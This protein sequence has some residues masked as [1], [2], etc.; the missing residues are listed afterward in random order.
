MANLKRLWDTENKKIVWAIPTSEPYKKLQVWT[1]DDWSKLYVYDN[2]KWN[3]LNPQSVDVETYW[4]VWKSL[5]D[6]E[7][8]YYLTNEPTNLY[9]WD[10]GD[11][12]YYEFVNGWTILESWKIDEWETPEYT[13]D[14]PTK[15]STIPYETFTFTGRKPA[16][17]PIYKKTSYKAQFSD[18]TAEDPDDLVVEFENMVKA[19]TVET[20]ESWFVEDPQEDLPVSITYD[21]KVWNC[22]FQ[23]TS[24]NSGEVL[25]D[26]LTYEY[27]G[28]ITLE[29][30]WWETTV[31][32]GEFTY[33]EL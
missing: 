22:I 8:G 9:N 5:T 12:V 15:S 26:S 4:P 29:T 32:F 13:W 27:A 23:Q 6:E 11:E 7:V 17:W 18:S 16:V 3:E 2:S 1:N 19:Q 24:E 31:V 33:G 21:G 20:F 25:Y 14:T 30:E 10:S 28:S